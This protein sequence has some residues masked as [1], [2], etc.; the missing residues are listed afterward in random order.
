MKFSWNNKEA[1]FP[2]NNR[3]EADPVPPVVPPVTP[4]VTPPPVTPPPTEP[5]VPKSKDEWDKLAQENPQRWISLTQT[6]MDQVVRQGR[7]SN[8]KLIA[9]QN[10]AKNLT[11]ELESYRKLPQPPAM[12]PNKPFSRENIPQTEEQWDKLW[13]ENP[14]LASDLRSH[15]FQKEQDLNNKQK[16]RQDDFAKSRKESA[17]ILWERHPD[18]YIQEIDE[19]GNVKLDEKG[20]PVLKIDPNTGGPTLNLE[21]EK[22]KLF[23]KVYSEDTAGYDGSKFGP[24]LAMSEVERRLQDQGNQQIQNQGAPGQNQAT[25]PDQRGVL[26]GG[27]TPPVSA[28][29]SFSSDEEKAHATRAVERGVYKS[30]EEYCL[31]R[32]GKNTG[33]VEENRTPIFK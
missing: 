1:K 28:K 26:P 19:S 27:V 13:I 2:F 21:S 25:A 17:K 15:K 22:G 9:E 8:E 7:E 30:I 3:G 12:D 6:R 33:F 5:P 20:K 31:L 4:P 14:N 32:D 10:K 29:V 11:A 24:R 18:M 23:V 16:V